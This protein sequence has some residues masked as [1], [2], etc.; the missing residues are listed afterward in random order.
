[1]LSLLT[2]GNLISRVERLKKLG[3]K[4]TKQINQ[5]LIDRTEDIQ[6]LEEGDEDINANMQ[7]K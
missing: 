6:E 1:M 2:N 4:T 5:T 7:S 3:V